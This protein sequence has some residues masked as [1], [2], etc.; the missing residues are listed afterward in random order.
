MAKLI[1]TDGV[2]LL[3]LSRAERFELGRRYI[4]FDLNQVLRMSV[5]PTPNKEAL[6]KK[7]KFGWLSLSDSG[8]YQNG[9]KVNYF[10]GPN[11]DRCIKV[12]LLNPVISEMY[13]TFGN[14]FKVFANLT[15]SR[16][17]VVY[18]RD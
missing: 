10:I 9:S 15:S 18:P 17:G 4:A 11:R 2:A 12:Q 5:E 13:L 16:N 8:E 3:K 6:G 14:Q 1:I 7:T